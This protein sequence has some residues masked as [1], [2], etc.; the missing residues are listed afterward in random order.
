[1]SLPCDYFKGQQFLGFNTGLHVRRFQIEWGLLLKN[2]NLALEEQIH[3]LRV[4]SPLRRE[5]RMKMTE[6][7]SLKVGKV[8]IHLNQN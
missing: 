5:A 3:S 6:L 2:K 1:M 7:L 8:S 4:D